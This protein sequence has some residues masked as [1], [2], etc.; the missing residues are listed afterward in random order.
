M[1][2]PIK[3]N[4]QKILAVFL[5]V[6]AVSIGYR[7]M[8]PFKQQKVNTLTFTGNKHIKR[9]IKTADGTANNYTGGPETIMLNLFENP[10]HHSGKI[11]KNIFSSQASISTTKHIANKLNTEI[12]QS[13][14]I[15]ESVIDTPEKTG[16]EFINFKVFGMYEATNDKVVFIERGKDILALREGDMID[17]KFLVLQISSQRIT[18][19]SKLVDK[20][21]FIDMNGLENN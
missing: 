5:V 14:E 4:K 8:H 1:A 13:S 16:S 2:S 9:I 20:P 10:P 15:A 17:G 19:K 7:I 12:K 21:F 6:L 3:N 11:V 18:L